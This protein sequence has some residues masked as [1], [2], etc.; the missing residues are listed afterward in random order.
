MS[1]GKHIGDGCVEEDNT[2]GR[3]IRKARLDQNLSQ[4]DVAEDCGMA[5]STV[6][7]AE[8][9]GMVSL[10]SLG[11]ICNALQVK[12]EQIMKGVSSDELIEAEGAN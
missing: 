1:F 11:R 12:P 7:K 9:C 10:A 2:L 8:R 6:S 4:E 3:N 5:K